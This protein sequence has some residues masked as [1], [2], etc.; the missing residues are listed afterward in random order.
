LFAHVLRTFCHNDVVLQGGSGKTFD[1]RSLQVPTIL[2]KRGW[3]LAGGLNP[4]NVA[5]AVSIAQPTAVDV[6]SGV[7]GP[8]GLLKDH[9][10]VTA[11]IK[12][13]KNC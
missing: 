8:D 13:A 2:P 6:S 5:D 4:G 12:A 7:C 3:L 11:F 9:E 10:K 1:W